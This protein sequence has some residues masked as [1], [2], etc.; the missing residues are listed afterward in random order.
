M[1]IDQTIN[2]CRLNAKSGLVKSI[3]AS[4]YFTDPKDVVAKLIIEESNEIKEK[5][6]LAFRTETYAQN[7]SYLGCRRDHNSNC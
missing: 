6:V 2:V 4:T 5:Q 1:A 3:L 7:N